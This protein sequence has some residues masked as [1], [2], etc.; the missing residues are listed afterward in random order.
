MTALMLF[1]FISIR[2]KKNTLDE[3]VF[4]WVKIHTN[5][6]NTRLM[7]FFTFLGKHQFLIPVNLGLLAYYLFIRNHEYALKIPVIALSSL[8]LMFLL[9]YFF[10]RSRP[11]DPLL[12][13]VS[14]LSYPSGHALMSVTFYGLLIHIVW[15]NISDFFLKW[16]LIFIL[17]MLIQLIGF[18]RIY[19]R[20]HYATDVLAGY[21][22]GLLWL[23][24]CLYF[25]PENRTAVF[26]DSI[27]GLVPAVFGPQEKSIVISKHETMGGK[28]PK[29]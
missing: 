26:E 11:A 15:H 5:E 10:S 3:K 29:K 25:L 1:I 18:S 8:G 24:I 9:K 27:T 13:K 4:D 12:K 21:A 23:L 20:V 17:L 19:L 7:L 22:I 28:I 14:G 6:T 16:V 2:K